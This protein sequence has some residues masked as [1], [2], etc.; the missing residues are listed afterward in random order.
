MI[1]CCAESQKNLRPDY[2][3]VLREKTEN[4]DVI[5]RNHILLDAISAYLADTL[6][7]KV[8]KGPAS[9]AIYDFQRLVHLAKT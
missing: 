1:P 3:Y 7:T 8:C 4:G 5:W 6:D 9:V 2:C